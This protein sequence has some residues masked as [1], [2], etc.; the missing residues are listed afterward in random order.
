VKAYDF[1]ARPAENFTFGGEFQMKTIPWVPA[2]ALCL[3]PLFFAPALLFAQSPFDGT[4]HTN[5]DQSKLSP[6]PIVFAVQAGT[7]ECSSCVPKISVKADGQ[8]QS[9][10]G[11]TYD[12][13]SVHVIDVKSVEVMTKKNG[14]LEFEQNRTVS[15]DGKTLAVKTTSHP[16]DSDQ[17]V[18]SAVTLTRVGKAPAGSNGTSGAWRLDKVNE[19]ENGLTTTY[20]SNGDEL[21]MSMP[22]GES[23]TA[24]LD[25][26]DYPAKGAYSYDSVSLKR[27]NGRTIEETAKRDGKVVEVSKI[28]VSPDGKTMTVVATSKLTG[29]VSTYVAQKQ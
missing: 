7:Y 19:S 15:D 6:K 21:T 27:I 23:Y 2:F 18:T 4:W 11:Q 12:S 22:T 10:T 13:I 25:G 28:A 29:R 8:P 1:S 24:K 20:K 3:I 16:K 14:K 17:T 26:K 5:M 9:V